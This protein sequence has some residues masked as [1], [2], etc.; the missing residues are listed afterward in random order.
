MR[1]PL[2]RLPSLLVRGLRRHLPLRPHLLPRRRPQCPSSALPGAS[3]SPAATFPS[4]P[5]A[6]SSSSPAATVA[7]PLRTRIAAVFAKHPCRIPYSFVSCIKSQNKRYSGIRVFPT[8]PGASPC[9]V[10]AAQGHGDAFEFGGSLLYLW[11]RPRS[12]EDDRDSDDLDS[13]DWDGNND[14]GGRGSNSD[15]SDDEATDSFID[16]F[17]QRKKARLV[18]ESN[19][20]RKLY[21]G[22]AQG[23]RPPFDGSQ[24]D[25]MPLPNPMVGFNLPSDRL[26]SVKRRLSEQ[27]VGPPF[28]Y[29]ENVALAPRGVWRTIS[30]TLYDIEPEFVDSKYLCAAARKRG[31]IHNLPIDNRSPLLPLP[32]KN[33]FK[34]FP[35]YEKWWPSWDPRRQLNCLLTSV[36]SA[37]LTERIEYA[38]ASSGSLPS[39][40]VQKYVADECRKWNL[41]WIGKNK[42]APLEPHEMEYLLGFPRD[43]TRG[44][45]KMERY[46]A[47]GN[48]FQV[49]AVAYHL[50]VL[51]DM[52][53]DGINVLSLFT[54]IGGGEV[55][56]H[57]LGVHMK[58]VV[59]VEISEV[60]R[61][62]FR[63]WWNRSQTGGSLIEIP[64]VETLTNDT[65]KSLL[66][67]LT[68]RLG[69][70]DLIIGGSPCNNLTGSNRHHRDGLQGE[71]SALFYEYSRILNAV[72]FV[73]ARM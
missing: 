68:K 7:V 30:R 50:S 1:R 10:R 2:R 41:V 37:K 38:L 33:I 53:R 29:Y 67:S 5:S 28:F 48:S 18:E 11:L 57:K 66:D 31:Y 27:A 25:P 47:L 6:A 56:L 12:T 51:R 19:K 44:V 63:G 61:R 70:F 64:N 73:M 14:A 23:N 42:V 58:T 17:G 36:A 9:R 3:F 40:S 71:Q 55:A 72:K 60:N 16:S 32:P 4:P 43:H 34:E 35:D 65:I 26:R 21:G 22:E 62:I 59:S 13:E 20:K 8:R 24:D 39:L 45:S 49:D 52:F 46:K 69:G 15:R 54:G